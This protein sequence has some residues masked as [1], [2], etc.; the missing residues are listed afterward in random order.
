M[1]NVKQARIKPINEM[2]APNPRRRLMPRSEVEQNS[3][4]ETTQI[5]RTAALA[6]KYAVPP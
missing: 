3:N 5:K 6:A 4:S 1:V 2:K